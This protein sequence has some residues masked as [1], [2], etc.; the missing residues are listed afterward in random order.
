MIIV[1]KDSARKEQIESVTEKMKKMGFQI[2]PVYGANQ[3][4][5]GVIGNTRNIDSRDIEVEEGVLEVLRVTEPYKLAGR[6]FHPE[7]SI[8]KIKDVEFGGDEVVIMAG[9]CS[10]ESEE[11]IHQVAEAV[12][13]SGA[14]VLRGGGL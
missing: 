8:I 4:V 1:M 2:H 9:P 10:V 6:A 3:T 11:Q 14:K 12:S 7:D 5:L 13:Q